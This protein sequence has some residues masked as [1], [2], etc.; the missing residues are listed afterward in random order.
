MARTPRR[1]PPRHPQ[2]AAPRETPVAASPRNRAADAAQPRAAGPRSKP[3]R[4]PDPGHIAVG[5]VLGPFGLKGELK[6]Q[7]LTDNR[8]R[9]ARGSKLFAGQQPVTV[10]ASRE[11]AGHFYVTFTGVTDRTAAERL[12][13]A[14]LQVPETSLPALPEGEYYRFQLIGLTVVD[15]VGRELGMLD[16]VIETGGNDVYRVRTPDGDDVLLPALDDVVISVDL[17]AKR[18]VVDPPEWR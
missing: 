3:Q 5:R 1:T 4:D 10:A 17:N 12:R 9:F 2:A 13:H 18:M 14:I 15:A 6:V 7:S 8:E 16:E 11:A